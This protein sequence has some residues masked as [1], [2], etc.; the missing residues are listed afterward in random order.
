MTLFKNI[1]D[2]SQNDLHVRV[3]DGKLHLFSFILLF[4]FLFLNLELRVSIILYI[5]VTNC[6][7]ISYDVTHLSQVTS[8]SH[9]I[10][11]YKRI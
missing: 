7:I 3:E 9:M 2:K 6:Y 5:T 10:T 8:H 4:L 11:Y 1:E